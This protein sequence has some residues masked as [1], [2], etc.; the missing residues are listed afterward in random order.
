MATNTKAKQKDIACDDYWQQIDG[1]FTEADARAYDIICASVLGGHGII[2]EV[3]SF[4]GR[5]TGALIEATRRAGIHPEIHVVDTFKGSP[6][7]PKHLEIVA[8]HGGSLLTQFIAN[9]ARY[10][11]PVVIQYGDNGLISRLY[12]KQSIDAVFI[13]ANHETLKLDIMHWL[14]KI[15]TG[16]I[17]AGHDFHPM[18]PKVVQDVNEWFGT[19]TVVGSCWMTKVQ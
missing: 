17:I 16:G 8:R 10:H 9:I 3:G 18:W 15:K 1:W 11:Y 5:S 19:V 7:E 4:L 12:Q 6:N 2:V 13:D 14:P